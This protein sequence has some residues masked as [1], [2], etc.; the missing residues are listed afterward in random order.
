[1][2]RARRRERH[3]A[4][5]VFLEEAVAETGDVAPALAHHWHEA[6]DLE[7]ASRY[8][9]AAGDQASRGWAK[10]QA[11]LYYQQALSVIPEGDRE[12]RREVAKRYAVAAQASLHLPEMLAG[13]GGPRS[14]EN[15]P[16]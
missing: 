8:Y 10:E 15:R 14:A 6:G 13:R 5:A 11:A 4:I 9:V 12:L 7:R 16:E 2:P 1:L 3:E